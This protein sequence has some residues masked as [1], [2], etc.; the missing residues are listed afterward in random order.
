MTNWTEIVWTRE[1]GQ[2]V[3]WRLIESST[4]ELCRSWLPGRPAEPLPLD[5]GG[6]SRDEYLDAV[7]FSYGVLWARAT[8]GFLPGLTGADIDRV[9]ATLDA[10]PPS[11]P[12]ART[13]PLYH[14]AAA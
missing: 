14:F 3:I 12:R 2:E 11:R 5:R 10:Q 13:K 9:R 6:W 4:G 8:E 1:P 7:G